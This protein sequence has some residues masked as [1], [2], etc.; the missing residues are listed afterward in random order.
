MTYTRNRLFDLSSYL[1]ALGTFSNKAHQAYLA[2]SVFIRFV[3]FC[4]TEW[5]VFFFLKMETTL[6]KS[7]LSSK[8][9]LDL[10]VH[11]KLV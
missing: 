8:L 2:D 6:K 7:C 9:S 5:T 4:Q 11:D 10:L 1:K 3:V